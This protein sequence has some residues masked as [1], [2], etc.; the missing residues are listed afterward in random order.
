[1]DIFR[2]SIF[3]QNTEL[4]KQISEDFYPKM[5]DEQ[6]GFIYKYNKKNYTYML[7]VKKDITN[8]NTKRLQKILK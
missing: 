7:P 2:E 3:E 6:N 5:I 1:M 8:M 4:L